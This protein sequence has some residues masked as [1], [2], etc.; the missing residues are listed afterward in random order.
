M[1]KRCSSCTKILAISCFG[2][3]ASGK[4][5][6]RPW[7]RECSRKHTLVYRRENKVEVNARARQRYAERKAKGWLPKA[8]I[9]RRLRRREV[10]AHYGGKCACCDEEKLEFLCMDHINGGGTK[11]RRE[12][13]GYGAAF[14]LWIKREKFPE[15]FR[16]LCWNCNSSLGMYGYCPHKN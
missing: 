10:I 5:G 2:K 14:Y 6:L 11:H 3:Q 8:T 15:G 9:N 16:V 12:I 4:D 1:P 13:G 7:C